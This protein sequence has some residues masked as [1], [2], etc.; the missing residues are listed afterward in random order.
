[1]NNRHMEGY[2]LDE[3]LVSDFTHDMSVNS[4]KSIICVE[5]NHNKFHFAFFVHGA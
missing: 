5:L 1:M 2:P 4:E 3:L